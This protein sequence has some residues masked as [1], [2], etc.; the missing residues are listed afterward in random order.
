MSA[1]GTAA[2]EFH[3]RQTA[4]GTRASRS[5]ICLFLFITG[6]WFLGYLCI[7][8]QAGLLLLHVEKL[9][10]GCVPRSRGTSGWA[11]DPDSSNPFTSG[12][13]HSVGNNLPRVSLQVLG[14]ARVLGGHP[15]LSL[16]QRPGLVWIRRC[17]SREFS[18]RERE[19]K[20][21]KSSPSAFCSYLFPSCIVLFLSLATAT[22]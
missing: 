7:V 16:V 6:Q 5:P 15:P 13:C 21:L 9:N 19:G 22:Q 8:S 20:Y 10:L 2:C 14:Y 4:F 1:E 3:M 12:P 17:Y 11:R 18:P